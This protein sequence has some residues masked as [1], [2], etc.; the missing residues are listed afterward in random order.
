MSLTINESEMFVNNIQNQSAVYTLLMMSKSVSLTTAVH[1]I[2]KMS[3]LSQ[4]Y[5][6]YA[7]VFSEENADK[8]L[9]H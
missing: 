9:S 7:D 3:M 6:K 1:V 8:L 4:Q 5:N 2:S